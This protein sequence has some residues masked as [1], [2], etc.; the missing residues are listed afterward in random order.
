MLERIDMSKKIAHNNTVMW[1][2][3][4]LNRFE[5]MYYAGLDL[6]GKPALDK[7]IDH[8]YEKGQLTVGALQYLFDRTHSNGSQP[9]YNTH[10]GYNKKYGDM[11]PCNLQQIIDS[12]LIDWSSAK[13][14]IKPNL[15]RSIDLDTNHEYYRGQL[16]KKPPV[17]VDLFEAAQ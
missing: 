5:N 2:Q 10:R 8:L 12:E 9:K 13:N 14:A 7:A 3:S 17:I 15:I 6:N 4:A 1:I 11:V 16:R